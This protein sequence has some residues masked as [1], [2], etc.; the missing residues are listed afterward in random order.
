M[1]TFMPSLRSF[2]INKFSEIL[3]LFIGKISELNIFSVLLLFLSKQSKSV[4]T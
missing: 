2:N 3:N 1:M 4:P